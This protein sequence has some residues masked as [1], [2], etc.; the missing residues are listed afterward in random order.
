MRSAIIKIARQNDQQNQTT[1]TTNINYIQNLMSIY[2][3]LIIKVKIASDKI[4][5]KQSKLYFTRK[6][7]GPLHN[8]GR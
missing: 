1:I 4:E 7:L 8:K 6:E 3:K 5:T 2:K